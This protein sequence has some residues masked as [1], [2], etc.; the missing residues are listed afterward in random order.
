MHECRQKDYHSESVGLRDA[1]F[2]KLLPVGNTL[3]AHGL[4]TGT[5]QHIAAAALHPAQMTLS[6]ASATT[7]FRRVIGSLLPATFGQ[8]ALE[9]ESLA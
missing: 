2:M 6:P 9:H 4:K 3:D 8:L 7:Q 5:E 1:E